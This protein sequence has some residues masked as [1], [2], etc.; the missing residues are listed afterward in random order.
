MTREKINQKV[1]VVSM[2]DTEEQCSMPLKMKWQDHEYNMRKLWY[3]HTYKRGR[4]LMHVFQV[5][6]GSNDYRLQ[7]DSEKLEW[8]LEEVVYGS[9]D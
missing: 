1:S 8:T 7:M 3:H 2:F 4:T 6:D 9:L 5:T